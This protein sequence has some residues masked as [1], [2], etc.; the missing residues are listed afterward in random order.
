MD[1]VLK[2][3]ISKEGKLRS[4]IETITD[5]SKNHGEAFRGPLIASEK[6]NLR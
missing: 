1:S 3:T 5:L 2:M 4:V 6:E